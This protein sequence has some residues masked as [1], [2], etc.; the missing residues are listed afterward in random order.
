MMA[1]RDSKQ[2]LVLK[3]APSSGRTALCGRSAFVLFRTSAT[4]GRGDDSRKRLLVAKTPWKRVRLT[5]GLGTRATNGVTVQGFDDH[6]GVY[7]PDIGYLTLY[8]NV[9]ELAPIR[10]Q[11]GSMRS[12]LFDH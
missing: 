11:P 9:V 6:P 7:C 1:L 4:F 12:R 2:L 5:R 8:S 10:E 3:L